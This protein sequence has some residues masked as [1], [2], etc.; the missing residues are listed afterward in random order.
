MNLDE[1]YSKLPKDLIE[2]KDFINI[3]KDIIN[4][5]NNYSKKEEMIIKTRIYKLVVN[6]KYRMEFLNYFI[7]NNL[8]IDSLNNIN[9]FFNKIDNLIDYENNEITIDEI[10]TLLNNNSKFYNVTKNIYNKNKI[11]IDKFGL[12]KVTTN[13]F[14]KL[15]IQ[16]YL[17]INNIEI[18]ESTFKE[19]ET[20][21]YTTDTFRQYINEIG[22]YPLLTKEE[23]K[24]LLIKAQN[25]DLE[26]R[27]KFIECNLKLVAYI[28]YK[29]YSRRN[30]PMIDLIDEGNIG[31]M[32]A[33][34]KYNMDLGVKFSSYASYWIENYINKALY[35]QTRN[36]NIPHQMINK[37]VNYKKHYNILEEKIGRKPTID[38][39]IKDTGYNE[40]TIS[41]INQY[42]F[43][44]VSEN[45]QLKSNT[46][47]ASDQSLLDCIKDE[48][49]N[50]EEEIFKKNEYDILNFVLNS[51]HLSDKEREVLKR[52][53]GYY[54]KIE[55]LEEIGKTYNL[56]RE[57]IRQIENHALLKLKKE[58]IKTKYNGISNYKLKSLYL[59]FPRVEHSQV[60]YIIEHLPK[61]YKILLSKAYYGNYDISSKEILSNKETDIIIKEI[62]PE[63]SK[64]LSIVFKE[65]LEKISRETINDLIYIMNIYGI[66]SDFYSLTNDSL[67]TG[68]LK[69]GY[70]DNK[71]YN[72]KTISKLLNKDIFETYEDYQNFVNFMNNKE[73]LSC[74]TKEKIKRFIMRY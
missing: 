39:I 8:K 59:F 38:E 60:D 50:V 74:I 37:M 52:R 10:I 48:N 63:I 4:K 41:L 58:L 12:S 34:E 28:V 53:Y 45:E 29:K 57:R 36:I 35:T 22:K 56:T 55:K 65:E 31:L 9:G 23:E 71:K 17:L 44:T 43:D 42:L 25:G 20:L 14:F 72:I 21:D 24:E 40:E 69:D 46:D 51:S 66:R 13:N 1:I 6:S 18:E 3:F 19:I 7:D 2:Y 33:I 30:L 62:V 5:D 11:K 16:S 70:I 15:T 27:N 67:T 64:L 73:E 32:K 26:A 47:E 49:S 68:L 54:G 61:E